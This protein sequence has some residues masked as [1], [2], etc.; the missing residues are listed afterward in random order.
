MYKKLMSRFI[1]AIISFLFSIYVFANEIPFEDK[2]ILVDKDV[3]ERS[4]F[5]ANVERQILHA[6]NPPVGSSGQIAKATLTL[7]D[8]GGIKD[9][10]VL[11]NDF[12]MKQSVEHAI[13]GI[14]PIKLPPNLKLTENN[15]VF[16]FQFAAR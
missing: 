2:N 11:S 7:D 8:H 13:Q 16:K 15:N 1:V 5:K 6:W 4:V 10:V 9:L 12:E 3:I 14:V